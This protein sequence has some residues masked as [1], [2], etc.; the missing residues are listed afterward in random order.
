MAFGLEFKLLKT[1]ACRHICAHFLPYLCPRIALLRSS[2][3]IAMH[4]KSMLILGAGK[5]A[6]VMIEYLANLARA[7][8]WKLMVAD[9]DAK[10]L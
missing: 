5:S 4:T 7:S 9:V 6:S 10:S 8:N 2:Q 1:N 3:P